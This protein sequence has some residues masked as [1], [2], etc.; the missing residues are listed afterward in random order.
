MSERAGPGG[1]APSAGTRVALAL[2]CAVLLAAGWAARVRPRLLLS[3]VAEDG[4]VEWAQSLLLL[5]I[6]TV[7][8]TAA[9]CAR[10]LPE[11][12]L[13]ARLL[14][15]GCACALF[16]LGEEISWGQRQLGFT[17]PAA[18]AAR[19]VQ[20]EFNFHNLEVFQPVRHYFLMAPALLL[21]IL[22][23]WPRRSRPAL[24]SVLMP[25]RA[26]GALAA[27]A[28][29]PYAAVLVQPPSARNDAD[30]LPPL[31]GLRTGSEIGELLIYWACMIHAVAIAWR[32]RRSAGAACA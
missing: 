15:L 29:S 8:A 13:L 19:N 31:W 21:V 11:G 9:L 22:S 24:A 5:C 17:T 20:G 27:L 4:V 12:L 10:R 16:V 2:A 1:K 23:L 26:V 14:A 28:L 7:L 18:F 6:A 30:P 32:V 25:S 3:W